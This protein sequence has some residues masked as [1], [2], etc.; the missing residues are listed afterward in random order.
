MST[1]RKLGHAA[2]DNEFI[3][4]LDR[5]LLREAAQLR[6]RM[7]ERIGRSSPAE[8][9]EPSI[10]KKKSQRSVPPKQKTMRP[11]SSEL[12]DDDDEPPEASPKPSKAKSPLL[13]VIAKTEQKAVPVVKAKDAPSKRASSSSARAPPPA[14]APSAHKPPCQF[15]M[16]GYCRDGPNCKFSHSEGVPD[17]LALVLQQIAQAE[18]RPQ[19]QRHHAMVDADEDPYLAA[20]LAQQ[21][22]EKEARRER[23]RHDRQRHGNNQQQQQ[24]G[25]DIDRMTY[26]EILALQEQMG[27][28]HNPNLLTR[29]QLQGRLP[30]F[31]ISSTDLQNEDD[32]QLTCTVCLDQ[33]ELG[34]TVLILPCKHKLHAD[35]GLRWLEKKNLCPVCKYDVREDGTRS[36][37]AQSK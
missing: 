19:R 24:Q 26:E 28:A 35:C 11:R 9:D 31:K 21:Q 36:A 22:N 34:D 29:K 2:C 6:K 12:K 25:P 1:G 18:R 20:Y 7:G 33:Y 13:P 16:A 23:R 14:P 32:A 10:P 8:D 17:E 27:E 4:D 5:K 30:S 3:E 37:V 15:F